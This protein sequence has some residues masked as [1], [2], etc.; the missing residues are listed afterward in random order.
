MDLFTIYR[1]GLQK[2]T[3]PAT[4][5]YPTIQETSLHHIYSLPLYFSLPKTKEKS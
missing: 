1:K 5:T 3:L 4:D 2:L